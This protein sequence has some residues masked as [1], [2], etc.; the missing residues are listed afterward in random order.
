MYLIY[1]HFNLQ[2]QDVGEIDDGIRAI[3]SREERLRVDALIRRY[4]S[5]TIISDNLE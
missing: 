2:T 1:Y 5:Y 4:P 3:K